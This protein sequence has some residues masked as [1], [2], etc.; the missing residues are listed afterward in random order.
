MSTDTTGNSILLCQK[1]FAFRIN[2]EQSK[3]EINELYLNSGQTCNIHFRTNTLGKRNCRSK[4][5]NQKRL[6]K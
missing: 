2:R 5:L 1:I 4:K 6:E 3:R